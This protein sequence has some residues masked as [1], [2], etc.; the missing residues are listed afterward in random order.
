MGRRAAAAPRPIPRPGSGPPGPRS[1]GAA[2][3]GDRDLSP[4]DTALFN[5]LKEW[6]A[7][8]ARASAVPAYVVFSDATLRAV[9]T[10]RPTSRDALL[11]ISGI[12][13]VKIERFGDDVLGIVPR[14]RRGGRGPGL[15]STRSVA[16]RRASNPRGR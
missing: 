1:N 6:R 10:E 16:I 5:A 9:A 14:G 7:R 12:G 3:A 15:I 2:P 4:A 11:A 8:V 13:P